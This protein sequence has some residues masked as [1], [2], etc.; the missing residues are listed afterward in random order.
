MLSTTEK[1]GGI[2]LDRRKISP[3]LDFSKE[4]HLLDIGFRGPEFTW[5]NRQC[6]SSLIDERLDRFFINDAWLDTFPETSIEHLPPL[7]S[8]HCQI[9]MRTMPPSPISKKLYRFDCRWVDDPEVLNLITYSWASP[10][11][12]RS[13]MFPLA[14]KLNNLRHLLFDWY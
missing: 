9:V 4:L 6:P 14:E 2:P 11:E 12:D 8:D 1:R 10:C 5:S 7:C 3:L 13:A